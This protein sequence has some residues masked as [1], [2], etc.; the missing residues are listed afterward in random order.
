MLALLFP[1]QGSQRPGMGAP[2]QGHPSWRLVASLSEGSGADIAMLLVEADAETL[3]ATA[4][5]QIAAFAM[6][7]V[8]LDAARGVGLDLDVVSAVAGH[9]LGE[10][11]ALVAAG[12]LTPEE[13]ARLVAARGLAMQRAADSRPG[14]MAAVLGL[15]MG[16][17]ED[18]CSRLDEV[19]V[20]NDNAPGQVVISGS[21]EGVEA[22][23]DAAKHLGAKR[24]MA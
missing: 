2:W 8:I 17:I 14:T 19:W 21:V 18:A 13:G 4:N 7:L 10:Y 11:T 5:A 23:S 6:S 15:E 22:G 16:Q 9:S 12:V 20:A 24:V 1:G 3:R